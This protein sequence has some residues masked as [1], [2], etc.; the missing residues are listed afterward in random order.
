M[1]STTRLLSNCEGQREIE[2]PGENDNH[3]L[4]F[5]FE[6]MNKTGDSVWLMVPSPLEDRAINQTELIKWRVT[7]AVAMKFF[8]MAAMVPKKVQSARG[9]KELTK[10]I[11]GGN[12]ARKLPGMIDF[13]KRVDFS[14]KPFQDAV[15]LA[16]S[17][18]EN[19]VGA[20]TAAVLDMTQTQLLQVFKDELKA[21][22]KRV[23]GP[24]KDARKDPAPHGEEHAPGKGLHAFASEEQLDKI[25]GPCADLDEDEE[26]LW[27]SEREA[28]DD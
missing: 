14:G 16:K 5:T 15:L 19:R 24:F 28:A 8:E 27:G 3:A 4:V 9:E 25:L 7:E 17:L 22:I 23:E 20:P 11:S 1:S 10:F 18:M 12:E 13:L 21:Q 2:R 6:P 26:S